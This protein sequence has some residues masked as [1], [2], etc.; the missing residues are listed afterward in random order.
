MLAEMAG[1]LSA[2]AKMSGLTPVTCADPMTM[3][4][5]EKTYSAIF[6]RETLFTLPNRKKLLARVV[7]ALRPLGSIV[8]TDFMLSDRE[9]NHAAM[10]AWRE[11]EQMPAH[12]YTV[13]EYSELLDANHFAVKGCDDLSAE[14]IG[15]IQQGWK[16]LHT[17]L[18]KAKLSPETATMLMDEGRVWLAR[19]KALESGHL[20]LISIRGGLRANRSSPDATFNA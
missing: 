14:Y 19:C 9:T 2:N 11:A 15:F 17:Y 4:F 10:K 16:N 1:T 12:P 6:V 8:L 3:A 7:P 20:R 18:Q 5:S 13:E